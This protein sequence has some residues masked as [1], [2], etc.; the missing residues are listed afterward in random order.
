MFDSQALVAQPPT[1]EDRI[2][3]WLRVRDIAGISRTTAWRLQNIGDFP[4][5][6]MLSPGRVGWRESDVRAW[7]ASRVPRGQPAPA[8]L[9]E[10]C[11]SPPPKAAWTAKTEASCTAPPIASESP[12]R[13]RQATRRKRP[14]A[15]DQLSFDF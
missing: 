3:P 1:H 6:V 2:L 4:R 14:A 8:P 9:F 13:K 12:V 10:P 7:R 5:P 15:A 11:S